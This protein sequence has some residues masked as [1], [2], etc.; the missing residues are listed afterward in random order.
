M[1]TKQDLRRI[2]DD[3]PDDVP[4]SELLVAKRFLEYLRERWN[5]PVRRMLE[6]APYEDEL[7]SE[8]EDAAVEEARRELRAGEVVSDE[9]LVRE[10]GL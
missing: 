4:A 5:D 7:I 10:L 9:Q 2:V 1:I 6:N 3:L 8:E